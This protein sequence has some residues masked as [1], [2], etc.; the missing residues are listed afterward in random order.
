MLFQLFL[1]SMLVAVTVVIHAAAITFANRVLLR[2]VTLRRGRILQG[3]LPP[4]IVVLWLI[5]AH[6]VEVW[7]WAVAFLLAGVF[8]TL[9]ESLY[10]S[11]VSFTT[12]GF[13]DILLPQGWR[14]LSGVAAAGGLILFGWTTAFLVEFLRL[15]AREETNPTL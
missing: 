1:G 8:A 2:L 4:V 11:L 15:V 14:L 3:V 7:V 6:S 10:F 5:F 9:E 12:L 13:G